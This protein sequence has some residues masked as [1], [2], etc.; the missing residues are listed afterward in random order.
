MSENGFNK[1]TEAISKMSL[2]K[3]GR[4]HGLKQFWGTI[5]YTVGDMIGLICELF[6]IALRVLFIVLGVVTVPIAWYV[7]IRRARKRV[8]IMRMANIVVDD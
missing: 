8:K 4:R 2:I 1:K 6:H 3:Y 5:K 7:I